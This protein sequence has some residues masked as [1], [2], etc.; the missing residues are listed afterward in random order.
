ME[1]EN[2]TQSAANNKTTTGFLATTFENYLDGTVGCW[3]QTD[4]NGNITSTYWKLGRCIIRR[5]NHWGT[6]IANCDWWIF[7]ATEKTKIPCW[8]WLQQHVG[9][10]TTAIISLDKLKHDLSRPSKYGTY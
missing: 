2:R 9:E 5:S 4:R 6:R 7:S 3:C 10:F 8:V 1:R